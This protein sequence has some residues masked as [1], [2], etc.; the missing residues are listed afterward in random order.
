[1]KKLSVLLLGVLLI[2]GCTIYKSSDRDS[3]NQN[4]LAGAPVSFASR[5]S[6]EEC[7]IS[8]DRASLADFDSAAQKMIVHENH[9]VCSFQ[10]SNFTPDTRAEVARLSNELQRSN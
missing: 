10:L 4:P 9:L 8:Q 2:T 3:F 1:M 7:W 5:L 6:A